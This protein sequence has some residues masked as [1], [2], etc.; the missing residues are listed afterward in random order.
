MLPNHFLIEFNFTVSSD[1]LPSVSMFLNGEKV[2]HCKG[3][4]IDKRSVLLC[5]FLNDNI[6]TKFIG[7]QLCFYSILNSLIDK[8]WDIRELHKPRRANAKKF[9][10]QYAITLN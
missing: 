5:N 3:C 4:G 6:G 9:K 10:E 7:G 8:G 2:G 1:G